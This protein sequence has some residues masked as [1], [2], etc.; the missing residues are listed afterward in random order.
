MS[1]RE[2]TALAPILGDPGSAKTPP[3]HPPP[4]LLGILWLWKEVCGGGDG[5]A[6]GGLFQGGSLF[7]SF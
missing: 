7:L 6:S 5:G 3:L 2:F 4:T 1:W